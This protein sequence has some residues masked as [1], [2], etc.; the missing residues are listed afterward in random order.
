M[1]LAILL[2]WKADVIVQPEVIRAHL[3]YITAMGR[4]LSVL[5]PLKLW[6]F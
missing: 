1:K 2:V 6:L 4:D 3:V 5:K